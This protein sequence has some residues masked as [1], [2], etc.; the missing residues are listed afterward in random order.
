MGF[1]DLPRFPHLSC[2]RG[3][4]HARGETRSRET[5]VSQVLCY[6]KKHQRRF[7]P[8]LFFRVESPCLFLSP[9]VR[10]VQEKKKKTCLLAILVNVIDRVF[11]F[12]CRSCSVA[13]FAYPS[14]VIDVSSQRVCPASHSFF[15]TSMP[16]PSSSIV[17]LSIVTHPLEEAAH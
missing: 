3:P 15:S 10:P 9:H 2:P 1:L 8:L 16:K 5:I 7:Y 17:G 12:F 4:M 13:I 14:H 6:N 11:L